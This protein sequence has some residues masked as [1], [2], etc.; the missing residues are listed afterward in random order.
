MAIDVTVVAGAAVI[1]I[2]IE[3]TPNCT[4]VLSCAQDL[5]WERGRSGG[6]WFAKGEPEGGDDEAA[7]AEMRDEGF[8]RR[9]VEGL[10]GEIDEVDEGADAFK[11]SKVPDDAFIGAHEEPGEAD[12]N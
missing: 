11:D 7:H 3:R 6:F 4:S 9:C 1:G 12:D 2:G 10:A 5:S 8:V